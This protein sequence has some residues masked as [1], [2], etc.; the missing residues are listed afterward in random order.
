M[1]AIEPVKFET[2]GSGLDLQDYNTRFSGSQSKW[3]DTHDFLLHK[4]LVDHFEEISQQS[5]VEEYRA[6]LNEKFK[7][8]EEIFPKIQEK[9]T[10][11]NF[12]PFHTFSPVYQ[13]DGV[14]VVPDLANSG[15]FFMMSNNKNK[16]R[17]IRDTVV[18]ELEDCP[19]TYGELGIDGINVYY[20]ADFTLNMIEEIPQVES[21]TVGEPDE[22]EEEI[23]G[24]VEPL[25]EAFVHNVTVSFDSPQ[26]PEYDIL[27]SLGPEN[28]IS[29]EV[30]DHSGT[31]NVPSDDDLIDGPAS[32]SDYI[33]ASQVF[34]ICKGVKS[35]RV[36]ELR[37]KT[38]LTNVDIIKK[39]QCAES[40]LAHIEEEMTQGLFTP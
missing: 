25:S 8:S 28:T 17:E 37:L 7:E 15:T 4:T 2:G 23:Y 27:F 31:D 22:F 20:G 40:V 33:N 26:E 36:G 1:Q 6:F 35:E 3:K 24:E 10:R 13:M 19:E 21:V 29:L 34:T 18:Q 30:E 39:D 32:E 9:V 16:L 12:P 14:V 11:F 5:V 38:E